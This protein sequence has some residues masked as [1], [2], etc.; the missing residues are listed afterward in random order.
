MAKARQKCRR[1]HA[2]KRVGNMDSIEE[3]L[4]AMGIAIPHA[5]PPAANYLPYTRYANQLFISGQLPMRDGKLVAAGK[6]GASVTL[7]TGQECAR[8]CAVNLLAQAKAAIGEL[9]AIRRITKITV[10]VA[11][12]PGFTT[13]HLVANG[14][15]DFLAAILGENG[16]HARSAVGV[17][18]LPFDAPVEIE[19]IIET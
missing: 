15:S 7:E 16:R 1:G 5:A 10:F 14:A 12:D 18:C 3:R 4:S 8:W 13:Q 9:S 19:A 2:A 6:L 17:P 11:S